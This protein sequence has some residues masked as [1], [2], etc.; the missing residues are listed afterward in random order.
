MYRVAYH[1]YLPPSDLPA[2]R[3]ENSLYPGLL[4]LQEPVSQTVFLYRLETLYEGDFPTDYTIYNYAGGP[5]DSEMRIN[6]SALGAEERGDSEPM[7]QFEAHSRFEDRPGKL[8]SQ[9]LPT[10][11]RRPR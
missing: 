6:I 5:F 4:A 9:G 8:I 3:T 10:R 11:L 2:C 7:Y 1:P